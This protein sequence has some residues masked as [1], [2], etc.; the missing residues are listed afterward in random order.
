M[1]FKRARPLTL[2]QVAEKIGV[3][4]A[5]ISNAF[6]RP[7]QLS[8]ELREDIL[9]ACKSMG[10]SG[11]QAEFRQRR[12]AKT[13]LI[14]VI[15]P[16]PTNFLLSDPVSHY[17][18]QGLSNVF[19]KHHYNLL[20]LSSDQ[21]LRHI[22]NFVEGFI[23]YQWIPQDRIDELAHYKKAV[24]AIDCLLKRSTTI[25]ID[26]RK[27]AYDCAHHAL[28]MF[29]GKVVI[30]GLNIADASTTVSL[31]D[32]AMKTDPTNIMLERLKGYRSAF[33]Q[34]RVA[35]PHSN[36]WSIPNNNSFLAYETAKYIL[37]QNDKADVLLCMTD[38]LAL[39]AIRAAKD[40][41]IPVPDKLKVIGFD[42][43]IEGQDATPA[44]TSPTQSSFDRGK[45]AA[46]MFLGIREEK[47]LLQHC[48][49]EVRGS[50]AS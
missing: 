22:V 13:K 1:T 15:T 44:L 24:I 33:K 48:P 43:T 19:D 11:P 17:M 7:S 16:H 2:K 3:S 28:T 30:L 26:N 50:S 21:T 39:N 34:K 42:N 27:A 25:N 38:C 12:T 37:K 47:S 18:L 36:I 41:G 40:L 6:N 31:K 8:M 35:L 46:K 29:S 23:V 45:A 4:S 10:Y 32:A 20:F 5:T 14:G 49:L 9:L